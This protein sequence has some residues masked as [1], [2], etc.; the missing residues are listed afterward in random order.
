[1][2]RDEIADVLD[3]T[4]TLME[5]KGENPFR[6][7]AYHNGARAVRQLEGS[8][9]ELVA[10]GRLGSVPGLG[11]TLRD[12]VT[13]LVLTGK[14]PFHEELR[15]SLPPGLPELL[16]IP[17][18]GPKKVKA[19]YDSLGVDTL[20]KLRTECQAGTVA[21]LKGFGERTQ[22]KILEGLTFLDTVGK[23]VLFAQA[24]PIGQAALETLRGVRGVVRAELCG[25]LRRRRDT[26]K[27]IDLLVSSTDPE[28]VTEAFVSLPGVIQVTSKGETKSSVV[29]GEGSGPRRVV[30]NAD[31]RVV[32][33]EQYPYA[34]V[35]FTGSKDHNILLRAR[36]ERRG[37]KLNEY[38][39]EGPKGNVPCADEAAVYAALGLDYVPP[40]MREATGELELA[41]SH[42]VPR[43]VEV[44]DIRG[45][46]HN[47]T[48]YSDGTATLE[49]MA[50][51]ARKLGLSYLGIGDHSQSLTV[52]NGLTTDRVRQ[53]Q[54]EIDALNARLKGIRLL[55]G[56]ECDILQD[57]S[58][59]Y[60]DDLLRT[61]DYVVASVHSHFSMP[62]GEMTARVC[63]ALSN[64][65]VTMLGHATGRLL[66][67][68]DGYKLDIEEVLRTAAKHG[69]MIEIN[70]QPDR[71]DLD[72]VACKRARA[73]GIPL[74][75]NPDAHA[76]GELAYY[77]YGVDVARRGWLRREDVFNTR[78]LPDVLKE[79]ER[80]KAR[81]KS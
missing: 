69:K 1:M 55:K 13:S 27:D 58:L 48:T 49:E 40:E 32:T 52:A 43:L 11:E 70:A 42:T 19:L 64:P 24:S 36:A 54:K 79:L 37:L 12:A 80:R 20:D 16:R 18:L 39:L 46:F 29:L 10:S 66:L 7:R 56:T 6:T 34:L 28:A 25:S 14:L 57:G 72:W 9:P 65:H 78:E 60:S 67:R 44:G 50:L 41:E 3:E 77:R 45:V 31:L 59:D 38:S 71:L 35:H 5:L 68:R 2:T 47:H 61:F 75:I 33:D 4:A 30:L 8:L 76:T 23:R 17:G 53:Q 73:L 81:G 63:R 22:E 51:A 21:G 62:A 15:A 74:V 26:A